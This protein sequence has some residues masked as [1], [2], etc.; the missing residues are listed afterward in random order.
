MRLYGVDG[1]SGGWLVASAD[2]SKDVLG[3][4]I[5]QTLEPL[6]RLAAGGRAL[7]VVE[8]PIRLLT[9]RSHS[10]HHSRGR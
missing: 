6:M 5:Q 4:Q 2:V 7:A 3:F 9:T 8:I 10:A 1:C